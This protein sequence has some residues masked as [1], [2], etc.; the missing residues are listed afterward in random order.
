MKAKAFIIILACLALPSLLSAGCTQPT[1]VAEGPQTPAATW[2]DLD[3]GL[4]DGDLAWS[5]ATGNTLGDPAFFYQYDPFADQ[6]VHTWRYQ[7]G[8]VSDQNSVEQN[9]QYTENSVVRNARYYV[10]SGDLLPYVVRESLSAE[11]SLQQGT[12]MLA[13]D[14]AVWVLDNKGKANRIDSGDWREM[15]YASQ[16]EA[17]FPYLADG[18]DN[19][20]RL[21]WN[22]RLQLSPDTK[23]LAFCSNRDQFP[24]PGGYSLWTID[25]ASTEVARVAGLAGNYFLPLGWLDGE[26]VLCQIDT[27][28]FAVTLAGETFAL[29]EN[30]DALDSIELLGLSGSLIAVREIHDES[31]E[32]CFYTWNGLN[33]A[34]NPFNVITLP[35]P[36]QI[37]GAS[38]GAL[39][40]D[41]RYFAAL[42]APDAY[43]AERILYLLDLDTGAETEL[44]A[45]PEES[46][47]IVS[48][49]WVGPSAVYLNCLER[50]A[51]GGEIYHPWLYYM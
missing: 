6:V 22:H 29:H 15:E 42:Y 45:P 8:M 25:L 36:V 11:H 19:S 46:G 32:I 27:D 9:A 18:M 4:E 33:H 24:K 35:G 37:M 2:V 49:Y 44:T 14:E 48:F 40:T 23:H 28:L 3:Q 30:W 26:T 17:E 50:G 43:S 1:Q 39:S 38:S 7:D 16:L 51:D 31:S 34:F 13:G 21:L 12:L 10:I 47:D 20:P 41:G 5:Y